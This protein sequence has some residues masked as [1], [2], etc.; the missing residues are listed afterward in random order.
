MTELKL[1]LL[2]KLDIRLDGEPVTGLTSAKA[3]ALLCY[4]AVTGRPHFRPTLAGLLWSDMPE[5]NARTN[6]RRELSSLRRTVRA[7]LIITR[8][9]VAFNRD[10]PYWLDVEVF[11][12][13][14]GHAP[15]SARHLEGI[16][17]LREAVELYRGDFLEGFYVRDAPA[18]EEWVLVQQTRLR[19]LALQALHKLS[20]HYA[21]Q[22]EAG[23]E[24]GIKYTSRLLALEP[25]R[26][27]AHRQ[28][29]LLLAQ[30]GQ[31]GAALAQY[32]ACQQVLSEDLGVEPGPETRELHERIRDGEIREPARREPQTSKLPTPLVPLVGRERELAQIGERLGDRDCRLLTLIGPGGSGK[33]RLAVEAAAQQSDRFGHGVFFVYLAPVQT[34]AAIVPHIAQSLDFTFHGPEDPQQQLCDYLREKNLLLILDNF[35]HLLTLPALQASPPA[36]AVHT[37]E[38]SGLLASRFAGD[39]RSEGAVNLVAA[40]LR[41]APDVKVL[42]TSRARLNA[43]GEHLYPVPGMDLPAKETVEDALDYSAVQL[44]VQSARRAQPAFEAD[45]DSVPHVVRICRTVQGMPLALLL[46]AS[47]ADLLSPAEIADQI[48]ARSINFLETD[49]RDVPERQRGMRAVFDHSWHLL[50]E[51]QRAVMQALSVFRGGFARE[52]AE[53]VTS[54]SLRD[55]KALVERSLLHRTPAGRYG[56]HELLRQYAAEKLEQAPDEGEAVRDRHSA[57]YVAA[58]QRW[59]VDSKGPRQQEALVE[60]RSEI[61][62]A[63][64]AWDW[65]VEQ[66]R[67]SRLEEALEGLCR[68]Y[69]WRGRY[70]EGEAMCRAATNIP[71]A[72]SR[73]DDKR[74]LTRIL[75]WQSSFNRILGHLDVASQLLQQSLNILADPQLAEQD[76]RADRAFVLRE[77][78]SVA[79]HSNRE[80]ARRLWE[81]SLALYEALGDQWGIAEVKVNLGASARTRGAAGE[82]RQLLEETLVIRRALGDRKGIADSLRSLGVFA[83][84]EGRLEEAEDLTRESIEI[85]R[86]MGDR[87]GIALGLSYLAGGLIYDGKFAEAH[88]LF[89]ETAAIFSDLGMR[90]RFAE[91]VGLLGWA[92]VNL[93]RYEDAREQS[94]VALT[95]FKE[96][97]D[98]RGIAISL[99]GLG[100]VALAE[101]AYAE[102]QEL[103]QESVSIFR[104]IGQRD[105]LALAL[106]ASAR[107]AQMLG[108][109]SQARKHVYE[110]LWIAFETRALAPAV[111]AVARIAQLLADQRKVERT[112]ELYALAT[113]YT[114]L[115]NSRY[116]E[117]T[118]AKHITGVAVNLP[119]ETVATAQERGRARDLWETAEELLDELRALGWASSGEPGAV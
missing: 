81:R 26:E 90:N 85:C 31:R 76:T 96:V 115:S 62:N 48:A 33:T 71:T 70:R 68:F 110:A 86:Q 6:L 111:F 10:A 16:E 100:E 66:G 109:L 52:A 113:R 119:P 83:R 91:V 73:A 61:E 41:T 107:V 34:V 36:G 72:R 49:W 51:P 20:V 42:V 69:E 55:L 54:A 43:R 97:G 59:A 19:E 92:L 40:V 98:Q 105:E 106:A 114:Y 89:E 117:D 104:E 75:A 13:S 37:A 1:A 45:A 29:M 116:W 103:L 74:V 5:A 17:R 18:F 79:F 27:E 24:N 88:P 102:A 99:L 7:H 95:I 14:A 11:E 9:E 32:E 56:M 82:A 38:R 60:I 4:L 84:T 94:Q 23:L 12:S 28:L 67:I 46:A 35:E 65:A 64:A 39:G 63:R 30:S 77:M 57:Y 112:V 80:E 2:G 118:A 53:H 25:S 21:Q 22:G 3:Q 50:T 78:G 108:Q 87:V 101:E 47:W 44:F 58:L 8:Q 15:Q 93:G